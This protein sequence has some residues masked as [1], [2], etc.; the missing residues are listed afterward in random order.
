MTHTGLPAPRQRWIS[1]R[2]AAVHAVREQIAALA[3]APPLAIA[4]ALS[5]QV[6]AALA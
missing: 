1:R 5:P 4:A 6:C 2:S 3:A